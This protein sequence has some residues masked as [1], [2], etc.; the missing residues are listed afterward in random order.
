MVS[1]VCNIYNQQVYEK[2]ANWDETNR[3]T[4]NTIDRYIEQ[5]EGVNGL[6]VSPFLVGHK[7]DL[8]STLWGF[9]NGRY[10]EMIRK[11]QILLNSKI[12]ELSGDIDVIEQI[13][14]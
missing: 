9:D 7:E 3:D 5:H 2:L 8:N 6:V 11:S 14:N 4:S 12:F 10:S 1:M 13:E